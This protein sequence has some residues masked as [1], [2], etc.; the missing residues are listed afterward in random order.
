MWAAASD[1]QQVSN[2]TEVLVRVSLC[3]TRRTM[4]SWRTWRPRNLKVQA[5]KAHLVSPVT[6]C[7]LTLGGG[8]SWLPHIDC[9][10][11]EQIQFVHVDHTIGQRVDPVWVHGVSGVSD[12]VKPEWNQTGPS[13]SN[14]AQLHLFN[15]IVLLFLMY[16][17]MTWTTH[18]DHQGVFSVSQCYLWGFGSFCWSLSCRII[19]HF[20][21]SPLGLEMDIP[22]NTNLKQQWC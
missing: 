12:L 20:P 18:L 3:K 8:S 21:M 9:N 14:T 1:W 13:V 16:C 22:F 11:G 17:K 4:F 6:S 5:L 7:Q 19:R 15:H 10:F 2:Q